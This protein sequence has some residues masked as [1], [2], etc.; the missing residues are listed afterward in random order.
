LL[1]WPLARLGADHNVVRGLTLLVG[2]LS[3]AL[4]VLWGYQLL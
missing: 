3:T 4:G 2:C 1:G